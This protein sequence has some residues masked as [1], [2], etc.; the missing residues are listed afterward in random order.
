MMEFLRKRIVARDGES[1]RVIDFRGLLAVMEE[2]EPLPDIWRDEILSWDET[3]RDKKIT[4]L[5]SSKTASP[6]SAG[7]Q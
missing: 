4:G 6:E 1:I 2:D 5:R 3:T 7:P